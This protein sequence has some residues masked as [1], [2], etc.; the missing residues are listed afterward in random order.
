MTV[1]ELIEDLKSFDPNM[2]IHFSFNYGDYS[3]TVVAPEVGTVR[4]ARVKYSGYHE[5]NR[6]V[7]SDE[8]S[9]RDVHEV[10]VLDHD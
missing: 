2:K 6:V 7:D 10:V 1:G 3:R 5:M 4:K 9:E 8:E